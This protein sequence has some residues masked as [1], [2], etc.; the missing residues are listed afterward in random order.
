MNVLKGLILAVVMLPAW[1]LMDLSPAPAILASLEMGSTV[2]VQ[3][4]FCCTVCVNELLLDIDECTTSKNPCDSDTTMCNNTIGSFE[5]NCLFG[6]MR[7]DNFS[8]C[9]GMITKKLIKIL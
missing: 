7:T 5:C 6:Y 9:R 4:I 2:Q 8:Y 1:I 3:F